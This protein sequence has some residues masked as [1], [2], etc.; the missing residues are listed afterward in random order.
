MTG[1]VD[2]WP[3]IVQFV[4]ASAVFVVFNSR[5]KTAGHV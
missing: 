5:G 2:Y 1:D 4:L 3:N